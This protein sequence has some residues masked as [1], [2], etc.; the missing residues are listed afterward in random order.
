[1]A[2]NSFKPFDYTYGVGMEF[3]ASSAKQVK[4]KMKNGLDSL[5][6]MIQSYEKVLKIDP[7]ADLSKLF[8]EMSKI[9]GLVSAIEK[10]ENPFASFVDKG[11]LSRIEALETDLA[12]TSAISNEV[13]NNLSGL[14]SGISSMTEALKAAG[15]IKFPATFDNLFGNVED[16]SKQIKTLQDQIKTIS[17][18]LEKLEELNLNVSDIFNSESSG[19]K[20]DVDIKKVQ[21]LIKKFYEIRNQ[22]SDISTMD[23]GKI[24]NAITQISDIG[25]ELSNA[26]KNLSEDQLKSLKID[27]DIV[28]VEIDD[29]I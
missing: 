10:S 4:D 17:D 20:K 28:A 9:Q 3:K 18:N 13:K 29:L 12:A 6:K 26:I 19:N 25:I 1:M 14:T 23:S 2:K 5:S 15:A 22:L 7:N 24:Q 16:K 27:D 11:L 8:V 21:D